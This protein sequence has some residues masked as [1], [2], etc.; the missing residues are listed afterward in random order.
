MCESPS[1]AFVYN[2]FILAFLNLGYKWRYRRGGLH[3]K[4]NEAI[5]LGKIGVKLG[6]NWL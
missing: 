6:K 3:V 4:T 2:P 1:A 5:W